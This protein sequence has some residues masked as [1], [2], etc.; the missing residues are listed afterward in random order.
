MSVLE[1]KLKELHDTD[2]AVRATLDTA[3]AVTIHKEAT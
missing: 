3:G 1:N 2:P